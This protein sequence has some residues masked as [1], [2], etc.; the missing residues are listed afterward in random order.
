[1]I[2]IISV[3]AI[4][5]IFGLV[6]SIAADRFRVKLMKGWRIRSGYC[7]VRTAG[8]ADLWGVPLLQKRS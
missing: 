3:T 5:L 7:R 1:V 4:G 2:E 8:L 6:L